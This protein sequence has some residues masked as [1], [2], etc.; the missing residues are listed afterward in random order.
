MTLTALQSEVNLAPSNS[1]LAVIGRYYTGYT[2]GELVMSGT[3]YP[4]PDSPPLT[5]NLCVGDNGSREL[6]YHPY[7]FIRN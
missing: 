5:A 6:D 1:A 7:E 3:P 2:S 4:N